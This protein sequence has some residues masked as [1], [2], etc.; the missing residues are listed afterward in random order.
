MATAVTLKELNLKFAELKSILKNIKSGKG[1]DLYAHLQEVVSK[2][3]LH[4]PNQ[5]YD[6]LE[7]VSYLLKHQDTLRMNDFLK[8]EDFRNYH[9]VCREMDGY[10]TALKYQ[11]G[12]RKPAAEGEDE[13][14]EPEEVPAVGQVP[15]LLA[16]AQIYQWAG[17]GFGQ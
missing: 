12:A 8:L 10:C 7:E 13:D 9:E 14:A 1:T 17:I 11:F 5:A 15:D 3:I 4:Y 2:L 16:D 6:K